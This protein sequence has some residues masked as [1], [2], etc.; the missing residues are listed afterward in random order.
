[1]A[2]KD[3]LLYE[4]TNPEQE[5]RL[6]DLLSSYSLFDQYDEATRIFSRIKSDLHT[7]RNTFLRGA[8]IAL[9]DGLQSDYSTAIIEAMTLEQLTAFDASDVAVS[10]SYYE[11]LYQTEG[12]TDVASLRGEVVAVFN[13]IVS[14]IANR[15][16]DI[17]GS[18]GETFEKKLA[19]V[20]LQQE[21]FKENVPSKL[22]VMTAVLDYASHVERMKDLLLVEQQG[23]WLES[24]RD[25]NWY[26]KEAIH[27]EQ[28]SV[29]TRFLIQVYELL[30][31]LDKN[32]YASG[33]AWRIL[34]ELRESFELRIVSREE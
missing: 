31:D 6:L 15:I 25:S 19:H 28:V 10:R 1:M 14:A 26:Q 4:K 16:A 5:D 33:E 29:A 22:Q 11:I 3:A 34:Q 23:I 24:T 18:G 27:A 21:K 12:I 20:V 8:L 30:A 17:T 9:K 2:L 7:V 32:K 13:A